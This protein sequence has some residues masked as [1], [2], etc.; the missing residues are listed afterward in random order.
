MLDK[1]YIKPIPK[2]IIASIKR[3]DKKHYPA[4]SGNT[5]CYSYLA[6]WHKELVKNHRRGKAL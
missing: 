4:P 6:T 2:T 1:N 5:R 3:E